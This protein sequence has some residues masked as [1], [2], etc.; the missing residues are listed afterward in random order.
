M[1]LALVQSLK[2]QWLLSKERSWR[3]ALAEFQQGVNHNNPEIR[4][5][6]ADYCAADP[7]TRYLLTGVV[8]LP[9]FGLMY[10]DGILSEL[11]V[12]NALIF[13]D[14]TEPGIGYYTTSPEGVCLPSVSPGHGSY[15]GPN[16]HL[17]RQ[18]NFP[19]TPFTFTKGRTVLAQYAEEEADR[20]ANLQEWLGPETWECSGGSSPLFLLWKALSEE[21][22][23]HAR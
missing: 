12:L 9:S 16:V 11:Q 19:A 22:V 8:G 1:D 5:F 23:G 21:E 18:G 6:V 2:E 3:Y 14:D 20:I 4:G 7:N 13:S 10:V 15:F 17:M